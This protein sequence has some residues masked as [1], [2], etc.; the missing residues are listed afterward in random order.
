MADAGDIG[1]STLAAALA[2]RYE[3]LRELGRGGMATVYLA[4]DVRH[5]RQVAI[6][7]LHPELAAV[8]GAERFL[9]E[10]KTT[11]NLQHPHILP[12]FDSGSADGQLFY[13][14]PFVEGE[15][16]RAR[17]DRETQLPIA[18]AVQLAREVADALQHA[19]DR[20]VIH[21]DIKP[22][23]ILLQ[24]GHA[25]VAD[26]GIALAVQQAGG[27]RMTQTGLSL[28][29]PQ[30]MSPEQ[31]MGEKAVDA[32]ADIYALGAVTYEM[33]AG[34]PPFSGPTPQA[35]M[36][37]VMTSAPAPLTSLR[38]KAPQHVESAVQH[39]LEKLPA[40]RFASA[41][42][43]AAALSGQMAGALARPVGVERGERR[44]VPVTL[45]AVTSVVLVAL[46]AVGF[47][48]GRS[49]ES[50]SPRPLR[51]TVEVP[52]STPLDPRNGFSV[53]IA[54]DGSEIVYRALG[55][56]GATLYRRPLN[57]LTASEIPASRDP[58]RV[59]YEPDGRSLLMQNQ[60]RQLWRFDLA[61]GRPT[62]IA[63]SINRPDRFRDGIV[64]EQDGRLWRMG[65]DGRD[66]R[67]V[68]S[69]SGGTSSALVESYP[70]ILPGDLSLLMTVR[71]RGSPQISDIAVASMSDGSVTRVGVAGTFPRYVPTG[72]LL[73]NREDGLYAVPF[74]LKSSKA[75]GEPRMVV[76]LT[77]LTVDLL[78]Y[79]V[80][81]N[82]T[83][84]YVQFG[85]QAR[86]RLIIVDSHGRE[87]QLDIPDG[88]FIGLRFSPDASR[89][90]FYRRDGAG[91]D[92]W[93]LDRRTKYLQRLTSDGR[94]SLPEWT[95]DGSKLAWIRSTADSAQI[96]WQAADGSGPITPV[97]GSR[98]KPFWFRFTPDGKAIVAV[99]GPGHRHDIM[100]YPI[101]STQAA[102]PLAVGIG[103]DLSPAISP[104]GRWMV[105]SNDVAKRHEIFLTDMTRPD[106]HIPLTTTGGSSPQW[107]ADG[108]S[109]VYLTSTHVARLR[110]SFSPRVEVIGVDSLVADLGVGQDNLASHIDLSRATGELVL[111]VY[112]KHPERRLV[113][114]TNWFEE[115]RQ[116]MDS[117][118]RR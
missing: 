105:S 66:R 60:A 101:D 19:H 88:Q 3:L 39:A 11:A 115:L 12:L 116:R 15:T 109:I 36:A 72:H 100:L 52:D 1:A 50:S 37:K 103:D 93:I 33:L 57:S 74:D 89:I 79:D 108:K 78:T 64:F 86:R 67:L 98:R 62:M 91:S 28:G 14:M 68:T 65:I 49:P 90:A 59:L 76:P 63:E 26:F 21:R 97:P 118:A 46:A 75:S 2:D 48:R 102:R 114:V 82:G 61:G 13:V 38:A 24:G 16:L 80:S 106:T 8:L 43:F 110:I 84:S 87:Q 95:P 44:T 70:S 4:R 112:T 27:Q 45:F 51:F 56:N 69:Q 20:G 117:A 34:E 54:N 41:S 25:L 104:D 73:F 99:V 17:L 107:S 77:S 113:V 94:S 55:P 85:D 7:V 47:S 96:V 22:E 83:L 40:D 32:R 5:A 29:T 71:P 30:Y 111:A 31:A 35:I 81:A 18:D 58:M 9:A 10:I 42:L 53:A 6:K 23:N 92:I